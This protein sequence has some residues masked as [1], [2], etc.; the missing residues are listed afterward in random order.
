MTAPASR[1]RRQPDLDLDNYSQQLAHLPAAERQRLVDGDWEVADQG[2]TL[3]R[4]RFEPIERNAVHYWDFASR[5]RRGL[6]WRR[7]RTA[8]RPCLSAFIATF[9]F[10]SLVRGPQDFSAFFLLASIC[11]S[12]AIGSMYPRTGRRGLDGSIP[13]RERRGARRPF[14]NRQHRPLLFIL[15]TSTSR[16][17]RLSSGRR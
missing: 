11:L 5:N 3:R 13:E 8:S 6:A 17:S 7:A 10:P 14:L 15:T 16:L 4:E 9:A 12:V 1:R 2:E